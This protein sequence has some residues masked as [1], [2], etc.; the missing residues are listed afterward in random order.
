M[1]VILRSYDASKW[2]GTVG[3]VNLRN[4]R[5]TQI[6]TRKGR[7]YLPIDR[8]EPGPQADSK[9]VFATPFGLVGIEVR[10][11]DIVNSF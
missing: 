1:F 6:T 2:T 9:I 5:P 7:A 11:T 10:A 3:A 8:V 4:L